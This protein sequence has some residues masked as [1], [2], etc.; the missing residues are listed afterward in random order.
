MKVTWLQSSQHTEDC[1]HDRLPSLVIGPEQEIEEI[2]RCSPASSLLVVASCRHQSTTTMT[3]LRRSS[4]GM[5]LVSSLFVHHMQEC[6]RPYQSWMIIAA[7]SVRRTEA[8]QSYARFGISNQSPSLP[9]ILIRSTATGGTSPLTGN[10]PLASLGPEVL[11]QVRSLFGLYR[12]V[13]DSLLLALL[14]L[15]LVKRVS[16]ACTEASVDD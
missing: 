12:F 13:S 10:G 7:K 14:L 8:W 1:Y 6:I 11:C 2:T 9:E 3:R 4:R 15:S 5:T 16:R